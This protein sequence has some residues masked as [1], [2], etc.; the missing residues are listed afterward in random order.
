MQPDAVVT[1]TPQREPYEKPAVSVIR[2]FA[3]EVLAIGCKTGANTGPG[4]QCVPSGC[5]TEGS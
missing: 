2:L 1:K 3:E 5:A 4:G